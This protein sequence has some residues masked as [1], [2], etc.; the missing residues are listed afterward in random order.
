[1]NELLVYNNSTGEPS[2]QFTLATFSF[3]DNKPLTPAAC[4]GLFNNYS[5]IF[6][7]YII[8]LSSVK[9]LPPHSGG[10]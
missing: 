2:P 7:S 8:V 1:M 3:N 5:V 10:P 4:N 9:P 6:H